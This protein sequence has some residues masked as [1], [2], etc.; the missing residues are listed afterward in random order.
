MIN[1]STIR[2]QVDFKKDKYGNIEDNIYN[3]FFEGEQYRVVCKNGYVDIF[4]NG[5]CLNLVNE[6][7]Q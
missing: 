2:N 7:R 3:V 1:L 6:I 5:V 4:L